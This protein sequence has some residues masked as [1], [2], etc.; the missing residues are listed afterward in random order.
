MVH[1]LIGA[2]AMA[3]VLFLLDLLRKH[4][5]SLTWWEWL[6]TIAGVLYSVFVLETIVSFLGEGAVQGAL[7]MG[8]ILGIVAVVWGVLVSRYLIAPRMK[9]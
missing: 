7:V 8:L 4:E 9:S 1:L 6:I 5:Q 3:V 2:A